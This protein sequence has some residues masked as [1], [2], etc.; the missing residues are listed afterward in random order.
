MSRIPLD[1]HTLPAAPSLCPP[2]PP[3]AHPPAP[4]DRPT[5]IPQ[6]TDDTA[7]LL[8]ETVTNALRYGEGPTAS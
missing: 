3:L 7:L 1:G 5:R 4:K 8:S 2:G 6:G